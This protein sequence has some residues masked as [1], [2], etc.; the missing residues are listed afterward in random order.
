M[1]VSISASEFES[2]NTF[3][4]EFGM[5]LRGDTRTIYT[6]AILLSLSLTPPSPLSTYTPLSLLFLIDNAWT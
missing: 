5:L 3:R 2:E 4:R 1:S 6:A